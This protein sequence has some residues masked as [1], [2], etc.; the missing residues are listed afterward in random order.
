M[1]PRL[2]PVVKFL[3][4]GGL[5]GGAVYIVYEQGLLSSSDQGA[6][7]LRKAQE[8]LP[9]AVE[10]WTR[11]FGWQ[12]PAIPKTEFSISN[13]WNAGVQAVI[14]ALSIAPTRA[15]EYTQHSWKYLKDLIK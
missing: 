6:E 2:L 12:L 4:K 11:Y 5:V 10:E 9:P 15:C 13:S 14:G 3:V 1:A 8:A 7:A